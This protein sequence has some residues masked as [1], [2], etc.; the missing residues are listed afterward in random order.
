MGFFDYLNNLNQQNKAGN[1]AINQSNKQTVINKVW[2]PVSNLV[3]RPVMGANP[4][5]Q[6]QVSALNKAQQQ[7]SS[8]TFGEAVSPFINKLKQNT[9]T[10]AKSLLNPIPGSTANAIAGSLIRP[11][12]KPAVPVA[13]AQT[14]PEQTIEKTFTKQKQI[15]EPVNDPI[16]KS[17][18]SDID[19]WTG[20]PR[21]GTFVEQPTYQTD[22]EEPFK[23]PPK[24]PQEK[25]ESKEPNLFSV[26]RDAFLRQIQGS[27]EPSDE[28]RALSDRLAALTGQQ[29][30]LG[31]SEELGLAKI[32][33]QPIA[34]GFIQGQQAALQRQAAAQERALQAQTVPLQTRLAQLQAER[35]R[36]A[37]IAQAQMAAEKPVEVGGRLVNPLT[38]EVIFAAPQE[39]KAP[40]GFTLG[41]GQ[42][43]YD[44]QGKLIANV[45]RRP[46]TITPYQQA[47]L[48]IDRQRLSQGQRPTEGQ[49]KSSIYAARTQQAEP[50]FDKLG[51]QFTNTTALIGGAIGSVLPD[52]F[53]KE[54]RLLF[55]QAE[56][57]FI[58]AI[59]RK[60]SGA[61]IQPHEFADARKLYI[62]QPGDTPTVLEQKKISRQLVQQGLQ[63]EAAQFSIPSGGSNA[64]SQVAFNW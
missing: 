20:L 16:D 11:L 19:P 9:G 43:R 17:K 51:P 41:E 64:S 28:E 35:A 63:Q 15:K 55:E 38:G 13:Q 59:L 31:A 61:T 58:T 60:E 12:N 37:E 18:I 42:A 53:K 36:K 30:S 24:E 44:A 52:F 57:N 25:K 27:F 39:T 46:E 50:V 33:D 6:Q 14:V 8:G 22:T 2:Q 1:A 45:G 29:A 62:P 48:D 56:R 34:M 49:A 4:Q 47:Q 21:G 32:Q 54:D 40:E 23:E 10:I 3:G 26:Q 5:K 7:A